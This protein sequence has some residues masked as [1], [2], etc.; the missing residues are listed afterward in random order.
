MH[1]FTQQVIFLALCPP[2]HV[3]EIV[4]IHYQWAA[5]FKV[6]AWRGS[7]TLCSNREEAFVCMTACVIIA[8]IFRECYKWLS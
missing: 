4:F 7:C 3:W 8:V 1:D 2:C 5:V 6:Q